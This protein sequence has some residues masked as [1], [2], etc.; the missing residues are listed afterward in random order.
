[1]TEDVTE[2]RDRLL[3][4]A[5]P[6]VAFDGWT[7]ALIRD[8]ARDTGI[9]PM[10]ARRAFPRGAVS[11]IEHFCDYADRRM[12]SALEAADLQSLGIRQRIATAIRTRL[13]QN[14]AHREAIRTAMVALSMP[15]NAAVAMRTLY[16]TVDAIWRAAGDTSTDFNFYTKRLM[17]AGVYSTTLLY[18]LDD[19]SEGHAATWAFLDRRIGDVMKIQKARG[20]I[21]RMIPDPMRL[22]KRGGFGRGGT[23]GGGMGRGGMGQGRPPVMRG[24]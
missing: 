1:M 12:V 11:M 7:D 4:A 24:R 5:L 16:R 15:Q 23:G 6:N 9:E 20:R 18:W 2:I 14:Q 21:E 19:N 8:A 22:F 13:E 10:A 3:E 17:L